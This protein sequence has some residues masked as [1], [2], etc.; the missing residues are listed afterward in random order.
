MS[1]YN[2]AVDNL[3][4]EFTPEVPYDA[5]TTS[6]AD[7]HAAVQEKLLSSEAT[8]D[9]PAQQTF[10]LTSTASEYLPAMK[11]GPVTLTYTPGPDGEGVEVPL[12]E[13]EIAV[14]K[15]EMMKVHEDEVAVTAAAAA[16]ADGDAKI[17]DADPEATTWE[18]T[19]PTTRL[20]PAPTGVYSLTTPT[21]GPIGGKVF[22][23]RASLTPLPDA[24]TCNLTVTRTGSLRAAP[25][26]AAAG[27]GKKG[28]K[29]EEA[30]VSSLTLTGT[31]D[32]SEVLLPG[33]RVGSAMCTVGGEDTA[34]DGEGV[35]TKTKYECDVEV[36]IA[37]S[38]CIVFERV[39]EVQLREN[40]GT[41]VGMRNWKPA[42]KPRDVAC[43]MRSS[44]TAIAGEIAAEIGAVTSEDGKWNE[45][46]LY[47]A[48]QASGGYFR[49]KERLLPF[50]QRAGHSRFRR[51]AALEE[52]DGY[53]SELF[54]AVCGQL[55][56]VLVSKF[57]AN[58][59][60]DKALFP[61]PAVEFWKDFNDGARRAEEERVN[62]KVESGMR[63]WEDCVAVGRMAAETGDDHGITMLADGFDGM[64]KYCLTS[65]GENMRDRALEC[66]RE[67]EGV[68][69][70]G[71]E[72]KLLMAVTQMDCGM[73]EAA[74]ASFKSALDSPSSIESVIHA[75]LCV[76][77]TT[78][79]KLEKET[80]DADK[81]AL[82]SRGLPMT[83]FHKRDLARARMAKR[84][85]KAAV[86]L[87]AAGSAPNRRKGVVALLDVATICVDS[88]LVT[89]GAA[90]LELS[91]LCEELAK[92]KEEEI[93]IGAASTDVKVVFGRRARLDSTMALL[94]GDVG[95]ARASADRS[96]ELDG[97]AGVNYESLGLA[98]ESCMDV[99][100]AAT[101]YRNAEV[102]FDNNSTAGVPIRILLKLADLY[103]RG[104]A[105]EKAQ[106]AAFKA[107]KKFGSGA[108]WKFAAVACM[109]LGDRENAQKCFEETLRIDPFSGSAWAYLSLFSMDEEGRGVGDAVVACKQSVVNDLDD[110][111]L[112]RQLGEKLFVKGEVGLA[113]DMIRRSLV[114]KSSSVCRKLLGDV[115]RAQK[116]LDESLKEYMMLLEDDDFNLLEK[117]EL[118]YMCSDDL[119]ILK[120]TKDRNE[121]IEK[122]KQYAGQ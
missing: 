32:F 28:A 67:S 102:Q 57:T 110:D 29:V 58:A 121:F 66:M 1:I 26:V 7:H 43:E 89:A 77:H 25:A 113:E 50:V 55:N 19:L 27:K 68:R 75:G 114:L 20:V 15:E 112:L 38:D 84:S 115:L 62:G 61:T 17:D 36:K 54:A 80:Y 92:G 23:S 101:A 86:E 117:Q 6:A 16:E 83:T 100:A 70:M 120:K 34:V 12:S 3:P 4:E 53:R 2:I 33:G 94:K 9:T 78:I 8:E 10:T 48:V 56:V 76:L 106:E 118:F 81:E 74:E 11:L 107:T 71:V 5:N 99:D 104:E 109:K 96:V 49:W 13:A 22:L 42:S 105:Y 21:G 72:M 18:P 44:L 122:Y 79:D 47:A 73:Y 14:V 30:E 91:G 108:A 65:G 87:K 59:A 60:V 41:V 85:L 90:A 52:V 35:E 37:T 111:N 24:L 93:E 95:G 31:V 97:S 119:K 40:M 46:T 51:K 63:R 88:K 98:L 64:A 69:A 116:K 82:R 45:Q 39:A 103:L